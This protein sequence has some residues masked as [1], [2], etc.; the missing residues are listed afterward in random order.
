MKKLLSICILL[1]TLSGAAN[2]QELNATVKV[3]AQKITN[4]DPSIFKALETSIKQ[5]LNN[6]RWTSDVFSAEERIECN[7]LIN[8]LDAPS[9]DY[10]QAEI[11]V[12]SRRPVYGSAF[13]CTMLNHKD[14][15]FNFN[16]VPFQSMEFSETSFLNNLT[17]VLS[18]YAYMIIA[19]DYDSFSP[20]GGSPYFN[21]ARQIV[22]N[23]QQS[24]EGG[25]KSFDK[26]G[27]NR[28]TFSEDILNPAFK[29][30]RVFLYKYHREGFDNF[31]TDF[32]NSR[33]KAIEALMGIEEI[34]KQKPNSFLLQIFFNSKRDEAINMLRDAPKV[35]TTNLVQV[36]RKVDGA[37]A[38]RWDEIMKSTN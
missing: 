28:F 21:K 6:T 16:Y 17:S 36:M 26:A 11:T 37:Y 7:F 4:M 30:Y 1:V 12:G 24:S 20:D 2:A 25:W 35:E 33:R 23:A 18:F 9:S 38:S 8:I 29:N 34:F 27:R 31:Y 13:Y 15:Q 14:E 5:F 32:Q 10:F 3:T 19:I 22:Q